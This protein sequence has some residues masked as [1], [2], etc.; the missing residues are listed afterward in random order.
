E[1]VLR[2]AQSLDITVIAEGIETIDEYVA[3]RALGV[4]YQQGY[5]FARPGFKCLPGC[6]VPG[7][8]FAAVA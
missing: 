6:E 2:I 5:L 1:G 3:L 4:R 8:R 7:E